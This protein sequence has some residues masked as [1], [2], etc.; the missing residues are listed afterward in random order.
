VVSEVNTVGNI[1]CDCRFEY[2]L[3]P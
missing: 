3:Y 2:D 1:G